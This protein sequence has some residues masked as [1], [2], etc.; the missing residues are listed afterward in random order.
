MS[1]PWTS[2][3]AI[4]A[5]ADADLF[6][7]VDSSESA[8]RTVS[9]TQ[10]LT[11]IENQLSFLNQDVSMNAG[12][13]VSG[14]IKQ[15]FNVPNSGFIR[16]ENNSQLVWNAFTN[17][18]KSEFSFTSTNAWELTIDETPEFTMDTTSLDIHDK[19][20][21]DVTAISSGDTT[22]EEVL[23]FVYTSSAIN[24]FTIHSAAMNNAPRL[25]VTGDDADINMV[26]RT[27]GAGE[28][29]LETGVNNFTVLDLRPHVTSPNL[30][31]RMDGGDSTMSLPARLIGTGPE[32][33]H[34]MEIRAKGNGAITTATD[35]ICKRTW[36]QNLGA[37]IDSAEVIT[38]TDGNVVIIEEGIVT[39]VER[40]ET[41][42]WNNGSV[43]YFVV[44]PNVTIIDAAQGMGT[45]F[46]FALNGNAN[47]PVLLQI[48]L[49]S[50]RWLEVSRSTNI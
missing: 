19:P 41:S 16:M 12:V 3:D 30:G 43:I 7:V 6:L 15:P 33:D 48:I 38:L 26:L 8:N 1:A 35:F 4:D 9:S 31:F 32:S 22:P 24:E 28:I 46:D 10:V 45:E 49:G 42:N 20:L 5:L 23:K 36:Q 50:N 27:K 40:M 47:G 2:Q 13:T 14:A 29:K 37:N 39:D 18:F 44:N 25:Q 21:L 34:D 11:Y 17:N